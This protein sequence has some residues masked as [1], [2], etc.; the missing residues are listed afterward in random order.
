[1]N[2]VLNCHQLS[3]VVRSTN[4]KQTKRQASKQKKKKT[5]KFSKSVSL[6][7]KQEWRCPGDWSRSYGRASMQL[8][9]LAVPQCSYG[10]PTMATMAAW[11]DSHPSVTQDHYLACILSTCSLKDG[12][13]T[14]NTIRI[15][16]CQCSGPTKKCLFEIVH[17]NKLRQLYIVVIMP[18]IKVPP[19]TSSS[20]SPPSWPL[21]D[22]CLR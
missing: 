20:A 12:H 17:L 2:V 5:N 15:W 21:M 4:E 14:W 19:S 18:V 13:I 7:K 6:P 16:G 3:Q 1:M 9:Q 22:V 10:R 8:W 11:Q